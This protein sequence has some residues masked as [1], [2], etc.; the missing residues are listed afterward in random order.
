MTN[1]DPKPP[2]LSM[3]AAVVAK[4]FAALNAA[5]TSPASFTIE[6]TNPDG[7]QAFRVLVMSEGLY[8]QIAAVFSAPPK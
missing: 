3:D 1:E 5:K 8:R 2:R 4:L 7:V 6:A